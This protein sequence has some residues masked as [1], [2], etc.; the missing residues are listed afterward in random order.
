MSGEAYAVPGRKPDRPWV[1]RTD[2]HRVV[3]GQSPAVPNP[4]ETGKRTAL[5]QT[6]SYREALET[7][8]PMFADGDD[9]KSFERL[10]DKVIWGIEGY[11]QEVAFDC[12]HP[13]TC[14]RGGKK[15]VIAYV[16]K[17]D[18][19][20]GFKM[21][22]LLAGRAAQTVNQNIKTTSVSLE[23][24]HRTFDV[25][26]YDMST[27]TAEQRR[28]ALIEAGVIEREWLDKI[29]DARVVEDDDD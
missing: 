17:P 27:Q 9:R 18:L 26:L 13:D 1:R 15:H 4:A 21:I 16:G 25:R 29:V 10:V 14:P 23:L 7:F 6:A 28:E 12:P 22:E 8:L 20:V 24:E 5:K 3:Q 11:P 19:A 2:N